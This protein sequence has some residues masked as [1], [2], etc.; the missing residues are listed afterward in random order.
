MNLRSHYEFS[1]SW[2]ARNR[3]PN[4][5]S[6]ASPCLQTQRATTNQ[7][8]NLKKSRY[9]VAAF[10]RPYRLLSAATQSSRC[11][12]TVCRYRQI[13]LQGGLFFTIQ[14]LHVVTA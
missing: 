8:H 4:K 1:R 13:E 6:P 2:L 10:F 14:I 7:V 9:Q 11:E 3:L 5:T 12:L